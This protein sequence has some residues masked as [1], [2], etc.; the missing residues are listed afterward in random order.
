MKKSKPL[1]LH[2][3]Q[4]TSPSTIKKK[5]LVSLKPKVLKSPSSKKS[6]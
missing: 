2:H 6:A 5:S 1:S 3:I 4:T